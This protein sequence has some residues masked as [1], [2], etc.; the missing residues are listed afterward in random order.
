MV[1]VSRWARGNIRYMAHLGQECSLLEK[2]SRG[3][4]RLPTGQ[5]RASP[6]CE[7][8]NFRTSYLADGT[9]SDEGRSK[10]KETLAAA[11]V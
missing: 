4:W 7:V 10:K 11:A 8:I 5:Q 6:K 9:M 1:D 2:G 3:P